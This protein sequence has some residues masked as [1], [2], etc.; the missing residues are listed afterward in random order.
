MGDRLLPP[1]VERPMS[2]PWHSLLEIA[3]YAPSPYYAQPWRLRI[4]DDAA[5]EVYVERARTLPE[6]ELTGSY[7]AL[8]MGLFVE[9]LRIAAAHR[10]M[11]LDEELTAANSSF[12]AEE[13]DKSSDEHILFA[14]LTLRTGA[15]PSGFPDELFLARRTSRL[16]FEDAQVKLEDARALAQI[17]SYWGYRYTQSSNPL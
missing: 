13:L 2:T 12:S 8:T 6:E 4:V 11:R 7:L 14:R 15:R 16:A 1:L 10:G 9:S 3:R 17:A 5:A